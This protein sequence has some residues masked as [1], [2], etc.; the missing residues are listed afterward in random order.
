[1][2]KN[3]IR[4]FKGHEKKQGN[5]PDEI[6][7]SASLA[8][9]GDE[10]EEICLSATGEASEESYPLLLAGIIH[11]AVNMQIEHFCPGCEER[12]DLTKEELYACALEELI[13]FL[14]TLGYSD[15]YDPNE[16][17]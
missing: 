8:Q 5:M 10:G 1:M 16:L 7:I 17:A 11:T 9:K 6:F 15:G 2:E 3:N 13:R 4:T 14:P 12:V